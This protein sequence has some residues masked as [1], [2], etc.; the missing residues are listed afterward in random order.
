MKAK[1]LKLFVAVPSFCMLF[2]PAWLAAQQQ[3]KLPPVHYHITDLG[4]LGGPS[5]RPTAVGNDGL[6][7]GASGLRQRYTACGPLVQGAET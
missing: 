3:Q 4:T 1:N 5:A 2:T 6:V 7:A